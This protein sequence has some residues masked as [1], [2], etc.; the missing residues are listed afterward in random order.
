[1][2]HYQAM[3]EKEDRRQ[4]RKERRSLT[5]TIKNAMGKKKKSKGKKKK[6]KKG[7]KDNSSDSSSNSDSSSESSSSEEESAPSWT[8]KL[9][10]TLKVIKKNGT[11]ANDSTG[12][13]SATTGKRSK[14]QSKE[15]PAQDPNT[16]A[17]PPSWLQDF[18][19]SVIG[20]IGSISSTAGGS[21]PPTTSTT[22]NSKNKTVSMAVAKAI[23]PT[24]GSKAN[25]VAK[26]MT[27]SELGGV[28]APTANAAC[29][30]AALSRRS[31]N[32]TG[33]M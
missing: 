13:I 22:S 24:I 28:L 10:Q 33:K 27:P 9:F 3:K 32:L 4:K 30:R 14:G 21:A 19:A 31:L 5:K 15:P 25:Q 2:A 29:V 7:S 11:G 23:A 20:S 1:M 6:K 12:A 8:K 26:G 17:N 18:T 16:N